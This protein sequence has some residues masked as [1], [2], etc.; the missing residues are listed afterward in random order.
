MMQKLRMMQIQGVM[1]EAVVR[2]CEP[3]TTPKMRHYRLSRLAT[4]KP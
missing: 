2:Y 3:L 4:P 1:G